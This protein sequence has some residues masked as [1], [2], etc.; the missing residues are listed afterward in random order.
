MECDAVKN[1][2]RAEEE[3]FYPR[4][5]V[6]CDGY[7]AC[8]GLDARPDFYPR[9]PVECDFRRNWGGKAWTYFYPRT[10]VECDTA[11]LR[12]VVSFKNFYPR[13]PVEC[14]HRYTVP[15]TKQ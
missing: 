4:T 2:R 8:A 6:E 10:P 9:T 12:A 5:P 1:I 3:N 7:G 15:D 13:T 14:D 11:T